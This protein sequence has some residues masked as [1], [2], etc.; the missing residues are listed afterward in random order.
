MTASPGALKEELRRTFLF[1]S[2]TDEQLDW[3]VEHGIVENFAAGVL[4]YTQGDSAENFY[5]LIEGEIQLVKRMEGKDVVLL[6]YSK[7]VS[8]SGVFRDIIHDSVT[9]S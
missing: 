5:V 4:V 7:L 2:L 3:L 8:Y 6:K 1:D 9:Q